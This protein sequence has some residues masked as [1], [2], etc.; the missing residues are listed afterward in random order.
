MQA[1]IEYLSPEG[2]S[3]T[4]D[5]HYFDSGITDVQVYVSTDV[6]QT[7]LGSCHAG[8]VYF[9]KLMDPLF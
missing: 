1:G 2:L 3:V 9:H 6:V 4:P 8:W 5:V 7:N